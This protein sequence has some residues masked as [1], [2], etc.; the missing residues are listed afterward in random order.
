MTQFTKSAWLG[1]LFG[2]LAGGSITVIL[3]AGC[4]GLVMFKPTLLTQALQLPTT[5]TTNSSGAA[6][7]LPA[8]EENLV[9]QT[10]KQVKPAVVS[11]VATA[12]VP[13]FEQYYEQFD[14]FGL[15]FPQYRQ[16]GTEKQEISSGSGF[17]V[18][19]DGYVVT[20]KHVV[21]NDQADYTVF[22]N[23]AQKYPATVVAR[24]PANDI[25]ILKIEAT[26]LPYLEFGNSDDLQVGQTTIAIGNALGE[27]SNSVSVGVIS[28]LS[29]SIVAG[30]GFGA[31]E[32]LE[33]VI[34][35]DAAIN[36]GNSG[37]PLLNSQG[38]VIGVN[39][40][41]ALGSAENIGFALPANLVQT[42][43]ESVKT[44]GT[45]VRPYLGV[46]YIAVTPA[47]Q[48]K[49]S[50]TVDYGALVLRGQEPGDLAVIPGSPADKAG[51]EENDIILEVDGQKLTDEVQL[52]SVVA[53]KQVGDTLQL[54]I[55]HDGAEQTVTVTL[56]QRGE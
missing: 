38:Q 24:D 14:P 37:G 51:I 4:I 36:Q 29:R 44:T 15:Q 54:K 9:V 5:V 43:V 21:E 22:L 32:Q 1:A 27:F 41:M 28:G 3:I 6:T 46:R 40:A 7:I 30:D 55:L 12:D 20:N 47:L 25:A 16:K 45:I 50:L 33:G 18:S 49:N 53:K 8:N 56:E 34:Q 13:V 23:D 35:T 31:T 19:A 42:V 2:L 17:I 39:V 48:E 26:D 11:I 10:V 52:A